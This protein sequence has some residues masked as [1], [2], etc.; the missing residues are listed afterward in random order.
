[1]VKITRQQYASFYGPTKG[2]KVRLGDS[3]L[4]AEIEHDHTSYG[5]ECWVGAGRTMRDGMAYDAHTSRADGALDMLMENATIIDPVLGIIKADIGIRDGKIAGIGKAG[6]PNIQDGVDPNMVCGPNTTYYP[7]GGLIVTPGGIDVHTHFFSA[8]QCDHALATGLT[9]MIGGA[10]GPLFSI[11]CGGPWNTYR[12]IEAS[13]KYPMNFGFLGRGSSHDPDTIIEHLDGGIIGVK[14]HEDYGA[15][16]AT[17]DACL[18]ASKDYDFPVQIHTDTMNEAGF[19]ESTVAAIAG[20][21]IHM[22]HVEGG[23]GGHAPDIIR[24][25]GELNC[26]TSSTNPTNPYTK[27]AFDEGLDMT[28]SCH[29]LRYDL[30]EDVAFAE[31]RVR[32]GT[33][34]AED[35]LH[36]MGAI[37]MF[38]SDSQGMGRINE[39]VSRC[40]QLASKMRD[41]R[42]RLPEETSRD[43]DNERIKRYIAKYTIN[44]ARAF[45]IDKY[46]GSLEPGKIADLVTW[47]PSFFGIKPVATIKGGFIA[48]GATGDSAGSYWATEPVKQRVQ[49]G[50]SGR[51]PASLSAVFVHQRALD[52]DV[53]GMLGTNKPLLPIGSFTKLSKKD[54]LH[55]DFCP[56]IRV[57]PNSWDVFVDGELATC[58]PADEVCLGQNYMLR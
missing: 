14:I 43:A 37:A 28:M 56:D 21:T 47:K 22:Y 46:V 29:L 3:S 20:R 58:E 31:S 19:Y 34:A 41:Q 23:G 39:V 35:V 2:D 50:G 16:P 48:H 40:W 55:N 30:P 36:D 10:L 54:M 38:G 17:I 25:N 24:C 51:A 4:Y 6:N 12:M 52:I 9:T 32:P 57:D 8:E 53:P 5:D 1:M 11:D 7:T 13:E 18:T 49:F 33:R 45:G 26:L 44:P 27:N 42:G 15:M